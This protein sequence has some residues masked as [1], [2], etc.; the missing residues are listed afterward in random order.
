MSDENNQIIIPIEI[1]QKDISFEE[2]LSSPIEELYNLLKNPEY[3]KIHDKIKL[4]I[5]TKIRALIKKNNMNLAY[6]NNL[7]T[8][9]N[10]LE[11]AEKELFNTKYKYANNEIDTKIK[12]IV[13]KQKTIC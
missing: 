9:Y 6:L 10:K 12:I 2:L 7:K 3:E 1:K 4:I 8:C 5:D 11:A 13:S